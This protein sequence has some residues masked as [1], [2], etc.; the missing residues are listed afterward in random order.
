MIQKYQNTRDHSARTIGNGD[1]MHEMCIRYP[2]QYTSRMGTKVKQKEETYKNNARVVKNLKERNVGTKG[3][4]PKENLT[5]ANNLTIE[6]PEGRES[7]Y[8]RLD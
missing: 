8:H 4:N 5:S 1:P 6:L 2:T 3:K 7:P